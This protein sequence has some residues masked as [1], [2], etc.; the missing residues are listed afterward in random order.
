MNWHRVLAIG[1]V[2]GL[3]GCVNLAPDYPRPTPV[4]PT[5]WPSVGTHPAPKPVAA[6][7]V[8]NLGWRDFFLDDRL[9][10]TV[11]MALA[12]NRNLR[13]AALN[14]EAARAQYRDS[15]SAL[16]PTVNASASATFSKS[17]RTAGGND[18]ASGN[19]VTGSSVSKSLS[20]ELGFAS[21]EIDFF[22]RL[23][24]QKQAAFDALLSSAAARRSTQISLIGQVASDWLTL[25]A[26][27]ERL[28]IARETLVNQRQNLKLV[29]ARHDYGVASGSDVANA[30][31][32]VESARVDVASYTA[33]I[34]QDRNA[35]NLIA[36]GTVPAVDLPSA[37]IPAHPVIADLPAGI[38]SSVL[39]NRPDVISAEY[40]LRGDTA[41]IGA[42]RAAFF[43]TLSLT[44][45]TGWATAGLSGL[46]ADRNRSW[47]FTPR[48]D[49]PIFDGGSRRA[50]LDL[51]HVQR[52]ID[53]ADYEQTIQTAFREVA[54]AL[55]TRAT[56]DRQVEAQ[57][58]LVAANARAYRLSLA[59][60]QAGT[61][62]FLDT[63]T[64]QRA[65]YTA[66][67]NEVGR[68]LARQTN[69]VTLYKVLGGGGFATS[70]SSAPN[71]PDDTLPH[72]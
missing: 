63:L 64:E 50:Q 67:Q 56:I 28:S 53:L 44:A 7:D 26:D 31:S 43:P 30:Q 72:R 14:I 62:S 70:D 1:A 54:D 68:R 13:I 16:F 55:A 17:G 9:R 32:A 59:R 49:Q 51:A 66:R 22:G 71:R 6:P 69:L 25:A 23:R 3:A 41:S 20:A 8:S 60:Y 27:K 36:G 33:A 5:L 45:A 61:D 48:I 58:A 12:N 10:R 65:L 11:A 46:F 24:N 39:T 4:T 38:P 19:V 57:Q 47:S 21:Y 52:N 18:T 15:G 34:A 35:L 2:A 42:A 40:T 29:K 37:K